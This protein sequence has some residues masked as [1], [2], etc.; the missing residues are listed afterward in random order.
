MALPLLTL[1]DVRLAFTDR[2]L[3]ADVELAVHPGDR[4]CLLGSNGCGKSSLM[5]VIEGSLTPDAGVRFVQPGT[6]VAYLPQEPDFGDHGTVEAYVRA[7]GAEPQVAAAWMSQLELDGW[8][9]LEHLS[10]GQARRVGLARALADQPDLLLLDEPTNHLDLPAIEWL[11]GQVERFRGGL[12]IISHDRAFLSRVTRSMFW[13]E[14]G[15]L[16]RTDRGFAEFERWSGEVLAQEDEAR[17]QLDKTI[18]REL[19]WLRQGISARR[20]R[21]QGRLRRLHTLRAERAE[22]HGRL[23]MAKLAMRTGEASG[24]IVIEAEGVSKRFGETR[25]VDD[26]SLTVLRGDRVGIVGANGCG[27]TTLLRLLLGDLEP[28]SGSVKQGTRLTTVYFDQHRADLDPERTVADTLTGGET[29]QVVV[30]GRP[31]HVMGYLKDFLFDGR[32]AHR[33]V[34]SLSG[35]ERNRLRLAK[36]L[37]E[38]SNLLVLDEPTNDLDMDTLELLEEMLADYEGTLLLVSHDR[39]FLDRVVTSTLLFGDDGRVVEHAGGYTDAIRAAAAGPARAAPPAPTRETKPTPRPKQRPRKLSFKLAHEL[40][41]LPALIEA[42]T[43]EATELE[44]ALADADF[45]GRDPDGF[46]AAVARLEAARAEQDEAELRWLELE[47]L[48]ESLAEG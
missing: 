45:Y 15:L 34:G 2:P 38:P 37:A 9:P 16:R 23:R 4:I 39:E 13:L 5:R 22:Q 42:L 41:G 25:V 28:D 1:K 46:N 10:G 19:V 31:R 12:V 6:R 14:G 3:F 30:G 29:D 7:G 35:G 26:L 18:A 44:A 43:D 48:R 17:R 27:K 40:E 47:E 36:V 33:P 21:N 32:H 20:T 24:N 8:S 11:E